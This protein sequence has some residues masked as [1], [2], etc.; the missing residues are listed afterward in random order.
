[1]YH[2]CGLNSIDKLKNP[3]LALHID[4]CLSTIRKGFCMHADTHTCS[5]M[6]ICT[7]T[8]V[9]ICTY[10]QVHATSSSVGVAKLR[11]MQG[12]ILL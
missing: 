11:V 7:S 4:G 2:F 10:A 3:L 1:M 5:Y 8:C 9:A 12:C 6:Y